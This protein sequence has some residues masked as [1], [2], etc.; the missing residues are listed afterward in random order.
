MAGAA[1]QVKLC[2]AWRVPS[3]V[4]TAIVCAL[5]PSTVALIMP[6]MSLVGTLQHSP[7]GRP[8]A[9]WLRKYVQRHNR[10]NLYL[11]YPATEIS[12]AGFEACHALGFITGIFNWETMFRAG[13]GRPWPGAPGTPVAHGLDSLREPR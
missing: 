13:L 4:V 11:H 12:G 10:S 2:D 6:G 3:Q 1:V 8:L 9:L 5:L 7:D